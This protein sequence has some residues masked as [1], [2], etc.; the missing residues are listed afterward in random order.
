MAD[1][2]EGGRRFAREGHSA[3]RI[4]RGATFAAALPP[5]PQPTY[6]EVARWRLSSWLISAVF[7]WV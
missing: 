7:S 3:G 2:G 6:T 1:R 5:N 4:Q